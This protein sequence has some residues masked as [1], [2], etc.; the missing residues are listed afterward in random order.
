M[1][2]YEIEVLPSPACIM[3]EGPHWDIDR[4]SLYYNNIYGGTIL[5][6][7]YSENKVYEARIDGEDVI[8]FIIPVKDTVDQFIIGTGKSITLI[9]WDGKSKKAKKLKTV[10]AVEK[11]LPDNR[12]NDAKCD[13]RNR[14]FGGTMR[15]EAK[16]DIFEKRLG[17]FYR[18]TKSTGFVEIKQK[19]GISNG[20][21]WNENTNKFYYI[22][23]VDLDV[24]EYDYNPDTGDICEY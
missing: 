24:K 12:F 7:D 15:L 14:F 16:G 4:Q 9:S 21:T 23:S 17:T 11:D 3:G 6:Y 18:Y 10:G 13:P 5:R 1:A 20:L 8:A 2:G 22:D 19:V